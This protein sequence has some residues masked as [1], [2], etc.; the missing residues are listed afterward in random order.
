[1][2][3]SKKCDEIVLELNI[4]NVG[5]DLAILLT[6]GEKHIGAVALGEI[7]FKTKRAFGSVLSATGHKEDEIAL[8]G[9]KT[10]AKHTG[11]NTA[12]I[13]G[14]HI[15]NIK[16]EQIKKIDETSRDFIKEIAEKI[17]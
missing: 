12:F 9:A 10:F 13:C 17:S 7:D 6:G 1:M 8:Y 2:I 14:I 4:K 15:E 16:T 5:E 3:F 11:K